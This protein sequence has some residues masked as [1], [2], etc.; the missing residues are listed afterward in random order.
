[1]RPVPAKKFVDAVGIVIHPNRRR[2]AWGS[3]DWE[4]A[5]LETG[6]MNMRGL[7][8]SRGVG[9]A[10]MSHLEPLFRAGVKLCATVAP[11]SADFDLQAIGENL[12]FLARNVGADNLCGIESANEY[13]KPSKRPEDWATRLRHFEAWLYESVKANPNLRSVPVVGPSIWGRLTSDIKALGNLEPYIDKA[14]L[15]YYTGGRRPTRAGRP[16][17]SDEGGGSAEYTL[18]DA[19]KDA[20]MLA[21]GKGLYVT[22]FGYP[23][24]GPGLPPSSGFIT[25][26]AAAK[27]L[28]RGLFDM[29]GD[30]VEKIFVYT[31]ID[32]VERNPPRYHGLMS[33]SL[34]R[35]PTFYALKNLMALMH[36][37]GRSPALQ[38]L[39]LTL[40]NASGFKS[41]LFQKS[42]GSYLLTMY[43][44]ADSYDRQAKQDTVVRP[45]PATLT[46]ARAA[47]S[48]EIYAPTF[49]SAPKQKA[50]NATRVNVPVGDQLI[51]LKIIP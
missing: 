8:G 37:S 51:V 42:D 5:F 27:Y 14:C 32:D 50:G 46:L 20:E 36:D 3:T 1:M 41:M 43:Q 22:E 6:V 28:L 39:D 48:I 15:H 17:S 10:A 31:L 11:A 30:G 24:A 7:V 12:D 21:P 45:V 25:P 40:T 34:E 29:F 16:S 9:R 19:I 49:D 38:P 26:N 47:R 4:R 44:D 35:R 18:A 2:S 13:N 23:I 33:G